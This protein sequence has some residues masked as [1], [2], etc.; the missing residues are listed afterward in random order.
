MKLSSASDDMSLLLYRDT[1]TD[2]NTELQRLHRLATVIAEDENFVFDLDLDHHMP[3]EVH[4]SQA[5]VKHIVLNLIYNALHQ[6]RKRHGTSEGLRIEVSTR[7]ETQHE[8][9]VK[10]TIQDN[11]PGIRRDVL[12]KVFQRGFT[13]RTGGHG[14]GL[15]FSQQ[16]VEY[17]GGSI[18]VDSQG[19]D[20]GTVFIIRLPLHMERQSTMGERLEKLSSN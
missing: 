7:Y 3:D 17:L 1:G 13:E 10:L 20:K 18:T 4:T 11:G 12:G 2:L 19:L 9:P 15:Y 14:L 6:Y 16:L 5:L 8:L